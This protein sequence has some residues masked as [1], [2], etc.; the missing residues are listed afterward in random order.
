MIELCRLISVT[1]R[2]TCLVAGQVFEPL[3]LWVRNP[4]TDRKISNLAACT[5]ILRHAK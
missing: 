3:H 4:T 2:N 5:V 1:G